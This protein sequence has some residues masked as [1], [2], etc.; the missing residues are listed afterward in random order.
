VVE[1]EVVAVNGG[2]TWEEQKQAGHQLHGLTEGDFAKFWFKG[3]PPALQTFLDAAFPAIQ[4]DMHIFF[5][6]KGDSPQPMPTLKL[7]VQ[8]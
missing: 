6:G 5:A 3:N 7:V 1:Q 2:E 4:Q 8:P